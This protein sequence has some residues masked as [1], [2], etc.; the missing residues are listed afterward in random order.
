MAEKRDYYEVLG[1][2]KGASEDEIKKAFRKMAMKYHPDKNPGNKE[3]EEK[4]KEVNEAYSVLSDPDKK[5]K[6]DRFGHAGVDPNGMGGA[7]FGGFGGA[8]G[9]GGFEDIFD[10]FGGAFGGFGGGQQRRSNQPRKGRDL[11]KAITITFEEAAFGCKKEISYR[12]EEKCATCGGSGAKPGTS[13]KTCTRCNGTGQIRVQQNTMLGTMQSV[14][15]CDVCGGT[16]KI[17]EQPCETCRGKGRVSNAMKVVV[18][19]PAGID[20]GQSIRLG[21]KGEAGYNGGPDGDL[22][23]T[24]RV[25]SSKQ[26]VR[27]GYNLYTNLTIP[28]TT[29]VLGGEV[30]VPT[31]SGELKYNIPEGTQSGTTF[32]MREQGIQKLRLPGKGDLYVN[33]TVEIPKKL[34]SEQREL[35]EKLAESMGTSVPAGKKRRVRK[36]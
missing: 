22:L 33:V 21:G 13:K 28:V 26:F 7:G 30:T 16:G 10:M 2:Q 32:R 35:F 27:D 3:A 17:I 14:H 4:F 18:T 19:I 31:L 8:G 12:R 9:F 1:L 5:S 11:Q 29:A 20:D 6:Y 23:V 36:K 24:I 15:P 34:T 25:K